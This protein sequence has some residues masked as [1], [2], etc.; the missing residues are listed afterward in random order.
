MHQFLVDAY[1]R[2]ETKYLQFL[3]MNRKHYELIAIG[4]IMVVLEM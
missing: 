2:L 1:C 4:K 3:N